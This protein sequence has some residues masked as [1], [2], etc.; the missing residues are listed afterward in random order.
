MNPQYQPDPTRPEDN[1]QPAHPATPPASLPVQPPASSIYARG[2]HSAYT[3]PAP[4]SRPSDEPGSA[5]AV[6]RPESESGEVLAASHDEVTWTAS[7]FIAHSKEPSWYLALGAGAFVLS[8]L[9]Y[10]LTGDV[11]ASVVILIGA[12]L[13]GISASRQPRQLTY[14]LGKSTLSIGAREYPYKDFRSFSIVDEGAFSSIILM[15]LKRFSPPLS[16]Y[17]HPD[18]ERQIVTVLAEHLP[19]QEHKHDLTE[20]LMRRIRF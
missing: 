1:S 3:S 17:Y 9:I 6:P 20:S 19:L 11:V 7:E 14:G 4:L 2:S 16:L 5:Y 18:N 12:A 8:L 15:P 10:W 13:F